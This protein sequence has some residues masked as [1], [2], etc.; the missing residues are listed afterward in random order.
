MGWTGIPS[1]GWIVTPSRFMRGN[2]DY[3]LRAI[4]QIQTLASYLQ[5]LSLNNSN[6]CCNKLYEHATQR[7]KT[8]LTKKMHQILMKTLYEVS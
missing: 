5:P 3:K 8:Y 6:C 1:R 7:L 4:T 2:Q